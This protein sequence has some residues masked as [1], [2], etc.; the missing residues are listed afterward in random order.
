MT[1]E[2]LLREI[3]SA[4][5][6]RE[7]CVLATVAAVRGSVPRE[8]GAKA[9]IFGDGRIM[10]TVGGGKFEALAVEDALTA[11][12]D[13]Q[14]ALKTYPLHEESPQSFGAI[15]GGEVTVLLEPQALRE[16]IVVAGA[17]HCG[18]AIC[19]MARGCGWHVTALDDRADLLSA[20]DAQVRQ[21]GPPQ[22]FIATHHWQAD[23]ALVLVSRNFQL[24]RDA[25]AAALV[26]PGAGYIG[27]IG[28]VR[29]VRRVFEELRE[30]GLSEQSFKQVHAPIG[31][32]V[33]AD[34]PAE[35]A[36]SVMAEA[37]RVLRRR[38]GGPLRG[39]I[40]KP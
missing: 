40:A 8:P 32:D 16:A 22:E 5:E 37:M 29:K 31:L 11:L 26:N 36:V 14:P 34:S 7:P 3:L 4:R 21:G 28:S 33:G 2:F 13:K 39:T 20:C 18:Q 10:G 24:D 6:R 12:K 15:C 23:E 38:D 17:G 9:L 19:H 25:L 27:M 30:L 35:I 1:D